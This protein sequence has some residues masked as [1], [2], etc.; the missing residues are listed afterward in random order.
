VTDAPHEPGPGPTGPEE[1]PARAHGSSAPAPGEA[2]GPRRLFEWLFRDRESG[3]IV[4]AQLPN[5]P[6]ALAIAL[7]IARRLTTPEGTAGGALDLAVSAA[8]AW[9]AVDEV[10][11]GVN[12]WRRILGGAVL[13]ATLVGLATT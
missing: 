4:I 8:I 13:A 7:G 11:R 2:R 6:L 10:L 5:L 9:W 3:R 12:P 1:R